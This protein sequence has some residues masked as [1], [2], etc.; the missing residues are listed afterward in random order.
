MLSRLAESLYWIGRYVERADDTARVLDSYVHRLAEDPL[1]DQDASVRSL[2]A[3]LGIAPPRDRVLR[4][5]DALATIAYDEGNLNAIAGSLDGAYENARRSRDI[6]SSEMWIAI[7]A[8]RN[9]L[10]EVR[11][12]S[13]LLGPSTFLQFVRERASLISGLADSTMSR[14]D[15]WRFLVLGRSIERIDM[16][17]RLLKARLAE[18]DYA[19]DW[20]AF[21]RASGAME[22]FMRNSQQLHDPNGIATFLLLDRL[23]PRSVLYSLNEADAR[24]L[25]LHTDDS[26]RIATADLVRQS[27]VQARS[28]LEFIDTSTVLEQLP[29]LLE[30]LEVTC[31]RVNNAI[32]ERFFHRNVTVSWS[33]EGGL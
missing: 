27:L 12:T 28:T 19:P 1:N 8:T 30:L 22:A 25:E 5:D 4:A 29:M 7:N 6:I 20:M 15:G 3:I 21:L 11:A 24:L 31:Y 18:V 10:P 33:Q 23:F 16:T 13:Q 9:R 2:F 17:S 14:D 26:R 32:T